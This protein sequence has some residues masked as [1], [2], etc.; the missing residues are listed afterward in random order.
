MPF[1][2]SKSAGF[3]LVAGSLVIAAGPAPA[4]HE[5]HQMPAQSPAAVTSQPLSPE[6][7]SACV[8]AQRRV[9]LVADRA[10]ARL[11]SARQ[12]NN[13]AEMRSAIDDLQAALVEIR[14]QAETCSPLQ[15]MADPHAGHSMGNM[16][17]AAP[18]A[19]QAPVM[20][21]G[22]PT[23]APAAPKPPARPAATAPSSKVAPPTP[24]VNKLAAEPRL[25]VLPA[26]Q[27]AVDPVC[28]MKVD[29]KTAPSA[30]FRGQTYYFC[31]EGDKTT[32]LEDPA[33]YAKSV[34][35]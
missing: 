14:T 32:F 19:P 15:S 31:S 13:P 30:S 20:Q 35:R 8:E 11:E 7:V 24:D 4:Q 16:P 12:S 2:F 6:L 26:K 27:E 10:N 17:P 33:K 25:P 1:R 18:V 21:P 9:A 22:T 28:G 23:P 3:T 5:G 29:P 34:T